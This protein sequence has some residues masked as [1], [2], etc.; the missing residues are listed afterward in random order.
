QH[1]GQQFISHAKALRAVALAQRLSLLQSWG[2]STIA[3]R[4][5]LID[6]PSYTLNH[7]EVEKA[8]E[9][10]ITFAE[11]LSPVRIEVDEY[12]HARAVKFSA[13]GKEVELP[14]RSV[15]IAAGTQPNTVLA[16]EEG[17]SLALD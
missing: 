15:L 12:G 2:G 5:R 1:I 4:R 8:L 17:V 6:S 11:G 10:G 7:E 16:R 9:E 3:Y 13:G 14:A